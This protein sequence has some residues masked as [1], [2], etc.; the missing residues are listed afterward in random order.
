MLYSPGVPPKWFEVNRLKTVKEA[1]AARKEFE[2]YR[3][4]REDLLREWS[5][6]LL[7][8]E[9]SDLLERYRNDYAKRLNRLRRRYREDRRLLRSCRL[10]GRTPSYEI[11]L[12]ALSKT[13]RVRQIGIWM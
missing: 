6:K 5:P 7:K 11:A 2:S 3:R 8:L 12:K 10:D 13:E 4:E 9:T 1:C